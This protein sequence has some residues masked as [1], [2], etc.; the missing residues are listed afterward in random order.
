MASMAGGLCSRTQHLVHAWLATEISNSFAP[1]CYR[2]VQRQGFLCTILVRGSKTSVGLT[3][4]AVRQ[5]VSQGAAYNP[6]VLHCSAL[7]ALTTGKAAPTPKQTHRT[8]SSSPSCF[9]HPN[10]QADA[11]LNKQQRTH[12]HVLF[13]GWLHCCSHGSLEEMHTPFFWGTLLSSHPTHCTRHILRLM[14]QSADQPP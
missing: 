8:N 4:P 5:P 9:F 2:E 11:E 12:L 13:A 6:C 3:A 14:E 1:I 7:C 10:I